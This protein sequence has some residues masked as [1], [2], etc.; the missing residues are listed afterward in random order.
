MKQANYYNNV[1]NTEYAGDGGAFENVHTKMLKSYK[2]GR[3]LD[4]GCG[5]GN[6]LKKLKDCGVIGDGLDFSSV[7]IEKTREK[8]P[9]SKLFLE[10]AL[11]S[12]IYENYEVFTMS[13]FLEHIDSD[14]ELLKKLPEGSQVIASV[15]TFDWV[16]HVRFFKNEQEIIERYGDLLDT[17]S[18]EKE[19]GHFIFSGTIK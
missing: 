10:E 17:I 13:E 11:G 5:T 2:G 1:F 4:V 14:R 7:G 12:N 3:V 19:G 6:F 9:N 18:L 15:P 16:S 8:C